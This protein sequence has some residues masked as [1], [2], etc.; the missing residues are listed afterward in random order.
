MRL[1]TGVLAAAFVLNPIAALS[2]TSTV[3]AEPTKQV[4]VRPESGDIRC[5]IE[6]ERVICQTNGPDGYTNTPY[7]DRVHINNVFIVSYDVQ[8][9]FS[10]SNMQSTGDASPENDRVLATGE[11][12][13]INGWIVES[14]ATGTRISNGVGGHGILVTADT[15]TGF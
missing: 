12:V 13:D 14:D 9:T 6:A 7:G 11:V 2:F 5:L 4:F 3:G 10:A 8:L 15:V 1:T